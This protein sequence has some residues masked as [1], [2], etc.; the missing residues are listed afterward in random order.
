MDTLPDHHLLHACL[1]EPRTLLSHGCWRSVDNVRRQ[2]VFIHQPVICDYRTRPD[3]RLD[4]I[5]EILK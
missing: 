5:F 1:R 2:Q 4:I 3:I